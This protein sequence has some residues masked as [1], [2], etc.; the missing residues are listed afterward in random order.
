M[1][2]TAKLFAKKVTVNMEVLCSAIANYYCRKYGT[3]YTFR[4][5]DLAKH[6]IKFCEKRKRS[7]KCRK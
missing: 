1:D 4:D 3:S 2:R 6:I 7:K 5:L